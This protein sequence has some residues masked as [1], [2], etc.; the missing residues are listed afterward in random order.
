[1]RT[2]FIGLHTKFAVAIV[3]VAERPAIASIYFKTPR[4]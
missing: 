2:S 3:V 4:V 1:V